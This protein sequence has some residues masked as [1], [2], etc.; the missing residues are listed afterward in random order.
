MLYVYSVNLTVKENIRYLFPRVIL[1][2]QTH[3]YTW[4]GIDLVDRCVKLIR[5]VF[6]DVRKSDKI[7]CVHLASC[8]LTV[9]KTCFEAQRCKYC[10]M[11]LGIHVEPETVQTIHR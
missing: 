1:Y 8:H 4:N 5:E 7:T 11:S 6:T 2:Q 10:N 3:D 9:S